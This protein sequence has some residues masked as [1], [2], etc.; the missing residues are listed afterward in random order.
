MA[1]TAKLNNQGNYE[2]FRD[3]QR[4]ATG[5]EGILSQ[6]GLSPAYLTNEAVTPSGAKVNPVTG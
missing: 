5:T 2:I 6:Y 1:T 4:I 3:G